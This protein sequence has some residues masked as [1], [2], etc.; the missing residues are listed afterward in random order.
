MLAYVYICKCMC[1]CVQVHVVYVYVYMYVC[2]GVR[3]L[4]YVCHRQPEAELERF[5]MD[6]AHFLSDPKS[7]TAQRGKELDLR[8]RTK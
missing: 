7:E 2:I 8:K 3:M 1:T 5:Q 4:G 6:Q